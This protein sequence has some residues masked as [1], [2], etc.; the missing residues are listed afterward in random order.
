MILDIQAQ[1]PAHPHPPQLLCSQTNKMI[2]YLHPVK[3]NLRKCHPHQLISILI[4]NNTIK[5]TLIPI[6]RCQWDILPTTNI[7]SIKISQQSIWLVTNISQRQ[8]LNP[9]H[10]GGINSCEG[11]LITGQFTQKQMNLPQRKIQESQWQKDSAQ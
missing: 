9:S 1:T 2:K 7:P 11:F 8:I 6:P 3:T 5:P 10:P 4:L